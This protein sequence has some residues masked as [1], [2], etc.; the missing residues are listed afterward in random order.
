VLPLGRQL[1]N[2][3]RRRSPADI[4]ERLA[5]MNA[6]TKR[7]PV[8]GMWTRTADYDH[9]EYVAALRRYDLVR[10]NLMRGTVHLVT[11]RQYQ[12]W[13]ACL[14]PV[15][16]RM[17][18][19]Y[20]PDLWEAADHDSVL[21]AGRAL[22]LD[23]PGLTR[24]QIGAGLAPRI[25]GARPRDLGFAVRMLLPVVEAADTDPWVSARTA[26]VLAESVLGEPPGPAAAGTADLVRSYLAAF[27][28]ATAADFGYWSGMTG[29]AAAVANAGANLAA[30]GE[31]PLFDA[32]EPPGDEA[33][34]PA[35]VLPEFDNLL[36]CRKD[37]PGLAA[38]K[39]TLIHGS[40]QMHGCVLAGD[41]VVAHWTL[42]GGSPVRSDWKSEMATVRGEWDTFMRWYAAMDTE[43]APY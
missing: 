33:V 6:Q 22:L 14:Q 11:R 42:R 36:F 1:L 43:T 8:V 4:V 20:C 5:G 27:G 30:T 15:A 38:A 31:R 29:A 16:E 18:R 25:P 32:G 39:H 35:F 23:S 13:R 41:D 21:A 3:D 7:G 19:Q 2:Q 28:P 12:A 10:A 17:V 26:Y 24:A 40:G 34:R 9:G 37:D